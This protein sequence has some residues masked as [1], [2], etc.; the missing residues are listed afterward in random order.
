MTYKI[1]ETPG[2]GTYK[3]TECGEELNLSANEELPECPECGND[4]FEKLD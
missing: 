1:G 2:E 4:E 3:C